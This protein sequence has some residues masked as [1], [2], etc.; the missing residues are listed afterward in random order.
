MS[1]TRCAPPHI[2]AQSATVARSTTRASAG[3]ARPLTPISASAGTVA[4]LK[5][6]S[7]SLRVWSIVGRSFTSTPRVPFGTRR[8]LTPSSDVLPSPVRATTTSASARCASSTKSFVP[9][10][11]NPPLSSRAAQVTPAASQRALGQHGPELVGHARRLLHP[12]SH[13][14]GRAL[15]LEELARGRAEH[16]LLWAESEVHTA[17]PSAGRAGARR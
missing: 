3:H 6:T 7:Q 17:S 13:E 2:S 15:V 5:L 16:L 12:R 1:S 11:T 9:F 14:S 8:R 10:R 4:S